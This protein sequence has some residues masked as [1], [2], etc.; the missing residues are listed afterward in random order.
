M[1]ILASIVL[2]VLGAV[3]LCKVYEDVG[4]LPRLQ[5]D[6]VIVVSR[7]ASLCRPYRPARIRIA[8]PAALHVDH[9]LTS[10]RTSCTPLCT[11]SGTLYDAVREPH[12]SDVAA[13]LPY[14]VHV[15]THLL[16]V[17]DCAAHVPPVAHNVAHIHRVS[18]D[19]A[20]V[21][22]VTDGDTEVPRPV[23]LF[24]L[25]MRL[26]PSLQFFDFWSEILS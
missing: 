18:H 3:G 13:H 14:L 7:C 17:L 22:H 25:R 16:R 24:V 12:A 11:H 2:A 19:V 9:A 15:A 1:L 6:F 5:Y 21:L 8:V 26:G 4:D 23:P 10:P 20:H